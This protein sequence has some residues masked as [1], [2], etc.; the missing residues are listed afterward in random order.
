MSTEYKEAACMIELSE[1]VG[2][3]TYYGVEPKFKMPPGP[4]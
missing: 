2:R 1:G 3:Y 4:S